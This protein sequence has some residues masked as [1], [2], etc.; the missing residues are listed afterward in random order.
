MD[1]KAEF[2]ALFE[3]C[4]ATVEYFV[5]CKV[6]N[7][8]DAQ[9]VLQN[10]LV[11]AFQSFSK[12]SNR[13]NFKKWILGIASHKIK[14]YYGEK[15]KNSYLPIDY[16]DISTGPYFYKH[17]MKLDVNNALKKLS[18]KEKQILYMYFIYDM[19][20]E[21]IS[22]KLNIP[23][24]TVKSRLNTAK[25]KFAE[26]YN[27]KRE[28]REVMKTKFPKIMP[29]YEITYCNEPVF[30]VRCEEVPGWLVVPKA[31]EKCSF[32]FY[33]EPSRELT[34][35]YSMKVENNAV[36]HDVECVQIS[37]E[38]KDQ[39]GETEKRT[40]FVRMTE[41]YCM[42][43]AEMKMVNGALIFSSF[44]DSDWREK[45]EIGENNC[46]RKLHQTALGEAKINSDGTFS[47]SESMMKK[48]TYDL[49]GKFTVKISNKKYETVAMVQCTAGGI[50]VIQ[51]LDRDGRTVLFRRFNRYDW[52]SERYGRLWSDLLPESEKIIVNGKEYIHWY[53]CIPEQTIV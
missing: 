44:M 27:G 34:D 26:K 37:V 10:I 6:S 20:Q 42:Y 43:I 38:E 12:L 32:A 1:N 30:D 7:Y 53:D 47:I 40:L 50:L 29:D 48:E 19:S 24:G 2:E 16:A 14:D 23:I 4:K 36:I 21:E 28:V 9:D 35:I 18:Q 22:E 46:G 3:E 51:Y 41:N 25:K 8:H 49:I 13:E 33:D 52:K 31:N 39:T 5:N 45:Y 15:T 17:D 11:S